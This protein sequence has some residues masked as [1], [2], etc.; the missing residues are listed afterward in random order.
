MIIE[1]FN[2][3]K[4]SKTLNA[5]N[6]KHDLK[7]LVP[8]IGSNYGAYWFVAI[9]GGEI[10]GVAGC[11]PYTDNAKWMFLGPCSV[12][13]TARG[14]GLQRSFIKRREDKGVV[15]GFNTFVTS[16]NY[17]NHFSM[18]S[19]IRAGYLTYSPILEGGWNVGNYVYFRKV[20]KS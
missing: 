9:E 20:L 4:W 2:K 13:P 12:A 1:I 14:K 15:L 10:I 11:E 17:N 8:S 3:T 6:T 16:I 5:F 7:G 19:F 18:N